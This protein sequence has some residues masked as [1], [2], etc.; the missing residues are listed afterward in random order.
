MKHLAYF[1][2][3][4]REEVDLNES[5]LQ[6]LKDR[7]SAI[8]KYLS[9]HLDGYEKTERQGSYALKTI[10]K[11]VGNHEYDADL[12]LFM[13]FDSEKEPKDYISDVY[14][15][16][17]EN[18]NY[19]D[20]IQRKTRCVCID[21]VGEFHLDLV[22]CIVQ[23]NPLPQEDELFICNRKE[24]EFEETDGTGY[25]DWFNGKTR[26]TNGQLK[27]D[28]RLLKYLR[29]HK[30]TFS[31][32]SILLTTLIGSSVDTTDEFG[33]DF[34]DIPTSLK[35]VSN[36]INSFL[37]ANEIMPN[38][39]NPVLPTEDFTRHWDQDK[40]T[41]FRKMFNTYNTK[42]NEAFDEKDH[43]KSVKKWRELF[44]DSFGELNVDG[45]NEGTVSVAS[46]KKPREVTPRKPY[47]E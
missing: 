9:K 44:G 33:E 4:L 47:A 28:T 37:Q 38:I 35:T 19:K 5:R 18:D 6:N 7:A 14:N 29:D 8:D 30:E 45:R 43:N 40:Y 12:L 23:K 24:N 13:T 46:L 1:E 11:P 42:I 17:K 27:R 31:A 41:N 10:I 26:I 32:K 20:K 34:K 15:C 39:F 16:L 36:R 21:Y 22:P 3:F 2:K 25:R